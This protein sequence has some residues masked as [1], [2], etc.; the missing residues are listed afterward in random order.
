MNDRNCCVK[1]IYLDDNRQEN[2]TIGSVKQFEVCYYKDDYTYNKR[3]QQ[4][5]KISEHSK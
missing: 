2:Q 1:W 4:K 5:E 3:K